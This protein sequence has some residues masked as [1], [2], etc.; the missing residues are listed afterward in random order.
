MNYIKENW[1][2]IGI[3]IL[4]GLLL[5]YFARGVFAKQEDQKWTICHKTSSLTHPYTRIVVS[6]KSQGGHFYD[7]GS[8]KAG[9]EL[10]ILL[11][12]EKECVFVTPTIS[13]TV[14]P[15][16]QPTPTELPDF[17]PEEG[18][19]PYGPCLPEVTPTPEEPR[20]TPAEAPS[21]PHEDTVLTNNTTNTPSCSDL[22]P[23]RVTDIWVE[24]PVQND[25]ALTVR[26]GT[27]PNYNRVHIRYSEV[28]GEWRYALLNTDNDGTETISGLKNGVHYWFQVAYVNGCSVGAFSRSFDPLP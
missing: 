5:V 23:I 9:H 13:P 10:D 2:K 20:V 26:W 17:C 22:T 16:S 18:Y 24:N 27:N 8:N 14:V 4:L 12:G 11:E 28:D 21:T 25:G 6:S 19:Q 3:G 15:T 7:N 1:V